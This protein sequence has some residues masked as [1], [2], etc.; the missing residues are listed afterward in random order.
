MSSH[1][2]VVM[3]Y[4]LL[5]V[6]A[7]GQ[8]CM[9]KGVCEKQV[10]DVV[11]HIR[12]RITD[13]LQQEVETN[14][15]VAPATVALTRMAMTDEILDM[16]MTVQRNE[17]ALLEHLWNQLENSP[18]LDWIYY[19]DTATH[20]FFGFRRAYPCELSGTACNYGD[21]TTSVQPPPKLSPGTLIRLITTGN[22]LLEA[23][24]TDPTGQSGSDKVTLL[25][26]QTSYNITNR[27]WYN[28][29]VTNNKGWTTHYEFTG[30]NLGLSYVRELVINGQS[31]G[32]IAADY[33]LGF[34]NKFIKQI[35]VAGVSTIVFISSDGSLLANNKGDSNKVILAEDSNDTVISEG[36]K[37]IFQDHPDFGNPNSN[38]TDIVTKAKEGLMIIQGRNYTYDA[39]GIQYNQLKWLVAVFSQPADFYQVTSNTQQGCVLQLTC[40][41]ALEVCISLCQ[42]MK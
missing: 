35:P 32:V 18:E 10:D 11:S 27:E 23:Y 24:S 17:I 29:G 31:H 8:P 2:Y 5:F 41:S 28:F 3:L 30:G 6:A 9:E 14:L 42:S 1:I 26:T 34:L 12:E 15:E 22:D 38:W 25:Y 36:A 39:I 16:N 4:S 33:E 40:L 19:G 13:R 21:N 20:N 37:R 7:V